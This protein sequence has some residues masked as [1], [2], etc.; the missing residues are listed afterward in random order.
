VLIADAR[1]QS[2]ID[3][4]FIAILGDEP[5]VQPKSDKPE[6]CVQRM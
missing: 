6:A 1:L 4:R 3:K 2:E 5:V